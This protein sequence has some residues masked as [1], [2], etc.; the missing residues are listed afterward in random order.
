MFHTHVRTRTHT[1]TH[2]YA[3]AH[4]SKQSRYGRKTEVGC[5]KT[6]ST[7]LLA[8]VREGT[9]APGGRQPLEKYE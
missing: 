6:N 7:Q 8:Y 5:F 1:N 9:P 3:Q 4:R 2:T